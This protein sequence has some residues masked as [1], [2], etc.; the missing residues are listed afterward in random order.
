[1][2]MNIPSLP[3][4]TPGIIKELYKPENAMPVA[5]AAL[6]VRGAILIGSLVSGG[7]TTL[8]FLIFGGGKDGFEM[9]AQ[10]DCQETNDK[11]KIVNIDLVTCAVEK[12]CG[13]AHP[14]VTT[15]RAEGLK[16]LAENADEIK[17]FPPT[18]CSISTLDHVQLGSKKLVFT[19]KMGKKNGCRQKVQ[20]G[21]VKVKLPDSLKAEREAA[22]FADEGLKAEIKDGELVVQ[23]DSPELDKEGRATLKVLVKTASTVYELEINLEKKEAQKAT[24]PTIVR[25]KPPQTPVPVAPAGLPKIGF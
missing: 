9:P 16:D 18:I 13:S 4:N 21:D 19:E 7:L 1:M 15:Q 17:V 6:S 11:G 24:R 10:E 23:A 2:S 8:G 20:E 12:T 22:V 25:P 14:E 5:G 3:K